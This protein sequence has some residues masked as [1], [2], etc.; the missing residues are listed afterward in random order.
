MWRHALDGPQH[1][2]R[3][4]DRHAVGES[5]DFAPPRRRT[6]RARGGIVHDSQPGLMHGSESTP[7]CESSPENRGCS[8]GQ[9]SRSERSHDFPRRSQRTPRAAPRDSTAGPA[10]PDRAATNRRPRWGSRRASHAEPGRS[11]IG[12]R[13]DSIQAIG[14]R[15]AKPGP[16]NDPP[17]LPAR[18]VT[19]VGPGWRET[20][21]GAF[22][23]SA[24]R[25]IWPRPCTCCMAAL[26][27]SRI[28]RPARVP[29]L[30]LD[31]EALFG[32][33]SSTA[34]KP[35][36][37]PGSSCNLRRRL[38]PGVAAS[39]S[40]S[41]HPGLFFRGGDLRASP[42]RSGRRPSWSRPCRRRPRACR[43]RWRRRCR[44]RI[45]GGTRGRPR[46]GRTRRSCR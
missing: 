15:R 27:R 36:L 10:V 32:T 14:R 6:S 2:V 46:R 1:L 9:T 44:G 8:E 30:G 25:I 38:L 28:A 4:G 22:E 42:S 23:S 19:I 45:S 24:A 29:I 20:G 39:F 31:G 43:P 35:F 17:S 18:A 3:C 16:R 13:P 37:L 33:S 26:S 7:D 12:Q 41:T 5:A 34:R 40:G 21:Q 11:R